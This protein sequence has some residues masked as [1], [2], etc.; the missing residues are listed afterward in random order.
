MHTLE[1]IRAEFKR[2]DTI[3]SVDS[4]RIEI[5]LNN[6]QK[7]LGSF[8]YKPGFPR[9]TMTV[10]ISRKVLSDDDLFYDT[11]RHEYAH[12]V[13]F[14][15]HPFS[16]HGHD[17]VWKAVCRKV[18]CTPQATVKDPA[19]RERTEKNAK[20]KVTCLRCGAETYYMRSGKVVQTLQKEAS[21]CGIFRKI[22]SVTC[23]KCGGR[24]FTLTQLH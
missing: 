14:I 8:S 24:E 4:S 5:K 23:R 17:K 21:R 2:L 10:T 1:D 6:A 16:R 3:C 7:R 15:R 11:V 13:V 20:Y 12:A 9:G 18:G 19:L 22:S